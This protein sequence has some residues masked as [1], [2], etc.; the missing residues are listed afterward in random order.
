MSLKPLIPSNNSIPSIPEP[1]FNDPS[2]YFNRELSWLDFNQRCILN[3]YDHLNPFLEQ[4]N[5]L[6]LLLPTWMNSIWFALRG[7]MT[8][9]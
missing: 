8:N 5:L 6:R 2:L 7:S 4:L 3:A 1:D 9:S